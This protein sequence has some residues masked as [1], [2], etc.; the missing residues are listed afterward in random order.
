VE[1]DDLEGKNEPVT[2]VVEGVSRL[3][4]E[5]RAREPGTP[6]RNEV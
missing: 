6:T 5:D 1:I 4:D 3:K 2:D